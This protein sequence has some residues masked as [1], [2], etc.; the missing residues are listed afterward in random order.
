MHVR[1][2]VL[3]RPHFGYLRISWFA[4]ISAQ[5]H[6]VRRREPTKGREGWKPVGARLARLTRLDAKQDSPKPKA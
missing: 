2:I 4:I 3:N 6:Q 1:E 5:H